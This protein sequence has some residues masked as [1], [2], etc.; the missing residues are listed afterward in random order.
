MTSGIM[1][2]QVNQ[3]VKKLSL[4]Q[5]PDEKTSM[6]SFEKINVNVP[7]FPY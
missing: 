2:F 7:N 4:E 5:E 6:F 3:L 1:Q